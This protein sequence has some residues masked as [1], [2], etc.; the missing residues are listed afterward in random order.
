MGLPGPRPYFGSSFDARALIKKDV[1]SRVF[2]EKIQSGILQSEA[3]VWV[4]VANRRLR[5]TL[6]YQSLVF[7]QIIIFFSIPPCFVLPQTIISNI[8]YQRLSEIFETHCRQ[9]TSLHIAC[10]EDPRKND[11]RKRY[12]MTAYVFWLLIYTMMNA[13]RLKINTTQK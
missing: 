7:N 11:K 4:S 10:N 12:D 9:K 6:I 8:D 3:E 2:D 5:F 1:S 13:K